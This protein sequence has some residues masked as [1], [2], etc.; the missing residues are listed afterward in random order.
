MGA[1]FSRVKTW[2]DAE[3][4]VYSDLNAEF[5]NILNNLTPAGVDDYSTNAAEMRTQTTPGTY[6][7]ESLATSLAGEIAR[8]R[9]KL[10]QIIG[11]TNSV[12]YDAVPVDLT[13]LNTEVAAG[14]ITPNRIVS[15]LNRTNSTFP[16]ILEPTSTALSLTLKAT[17]GNPL[18][19]YIDGTKYTIS[20]D[21][22]ITGLTAAPSSNNTATLDFS[23]LEVGSDPFNVF[24][25]ER[26]EPMFL[27]GAPGTNISSAV[28][29]TLAFQIEDAANTIEY[30][31]ATYNNLITGYQLINAT[32]AYFFDVARAPVPHCA[33]SADHT[34]TLLKLGWV[35]VT[36]TGTLDATYNPPSY[37]GTE[38]TG[39]S[40]GDYWYDI[41]NETWKKYSG[42]GW[43]AAN[44]TIVGIFC[45]TTAGCVGARPYDYHRSYDKRN[46]IILSR[47]DADT[48]LRSH[49]SNVSI[50]VAGKLI[51]YQHSQFSVNITDHVA[52]G[53][54]VATNKSYAVYVTRT[55]EPKI[56][57]V[58][59]IDYMNSRGGY[60]HRY[61]DWR[62]VGYFTYPSAAFLSISGPAFPADFTGVGCDSHRYGITPGFFSTDASDRFTATISTSTPTT[63]G[64]NI[65]FT[66]SGGIVEVTIHG[67]I[68]CTDDGSLQEDFNFTL[69]RDDDFTF[70][71]AG[72]IATHSLA[73]A[74]Q[75]A[76]TIQ[77]S[78]V[79]FY[80]KPTST[81]TTNP[82]NTGFNALDLRVYPTDTNDSIKFTLTDI[83]LKEFP[84][85]VLPG[86][87]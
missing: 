59:P 3:D 26:G 79:T 33:I 65:P 31:T 74:T 4:V 6:G 39:P 22:T 36:T 81:S 83:S 7:S 53:V 8:L 80:I 9:F 51:E 71:T 68:E 43:A 46:D 57:T 75:F 20:A 47:Q 84:I 11:G 25:G 32:R 55:G 82:L 28:G 13:S 15:G 12:W 21:V 41:T 70:G 63:A 18:I 34:I 60:Y 85:G 35:F 40:T 62:C 64:L 14:I 29:R 58:H 52:S 30:F 72:E 69:Y 19:Y 76:G 56:D 27:T 38:P 45:N 61:H 67:A 54:T 49:K 87:L 73:F 66:Y 16:N 78:N 48:N 77:L 17:S 86:G 37:T 2:V 42:S 10:D 23:A 50:N 5:D 1:T 44:A 24:V